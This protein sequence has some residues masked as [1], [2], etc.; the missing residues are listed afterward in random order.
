MKNIYLKILA[1]AL[2]FVMAFGV[3]ACSNKPETPSD[4][5]SGGGQTVSPL[6]SDG[7]HQIKNTE[8]DHDFIKNGKSDYKI[9]TPKTPSAI[10]SYAAEE[11]RTLILEATGISLP[12]VTDASVSYAD[13][14][15]VISLG[16]NELFAKSGIKLTEDLEN[17]G[18]IIKTVGKNVFIAGLNDFATT[19]GAIGFLE[20]EFNFDMISGDTYTLNK[21]VT[22]AK[23]KNYDVKDV[24]D[25]NV[26]KLTNPFMTENPSNLY[27]MKLT[28]NN[29]DLMLGGTSVHSSFTWIPKETYNNPADTANYH[30]KWFSVDGTQLC[31]LAR[32]DEQ[33]RK[34]LEDAFFNQMIAKTKGNSNGY[35]YSL[36]QADKYT[37]CQCEAC[38]AET[39]KYNGSNASSM[40][41]MCN[42]LAERIEAWMNTE[43]GKPYKRDFKIFFLAYN[44]TLGAP[45]NYDEATDTFSIIDGL[46]CHD[47]VSVYIAPIEMSFVKSMTDTENS[48]FY[49][50]FRGWSLV[51]NNIMYFDYISNY[52]DFLV[53]YDV[54]N[55]LQESI[56]RVAKADGY[57]YSALG[58]YGHSN[59]ATGWQ[60]LRSYLVSEL[61]WNVNLSV[62]ELTDK[63]FDNFYADGSENMRKYYDEYRVQSKYATDAGIMSATGVYGKV[64]DRGYFPK[65]LVERW[66]GYCDQAIQDISYLKQVDM[67]E[68]VKIYNHIITERVSL[69]YM[70]VQ[71]YEGEYPDEYIN[72]IKNQCRKDC[73]TVGISACAEADPISDL[74]QAWGIN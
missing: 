64:I 49:N 13:D 58:Q 10:M 27:R 39:A 38:L 37:W 18:Y 16:N 15:K 70:T 74:W 65:N 50:A 28:P 35:I 26:R 22:N 72:N 17:N 51:C 68:Y 52:N 6:Y 55:T 14:A 20:L 12:V 73:E 54:F 48:R 69:Y 23:L 7:I 3:V 53:S 9:V 24:P 25:I 43:E 41:K 57:M 34:A 42:A 36:T 30:P 71:L 1:V 40:I 31:W 2:C 56:A 32:G 8:T 66:I 5:P 19:Y 29:N 59:A 45:V 62:D 67:E 44:K 21:N 11:I 47:R 46:T 60:F 33:E 63:F 61:A 4:G